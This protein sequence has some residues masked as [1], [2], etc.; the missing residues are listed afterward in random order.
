MML[1]GVISAPNIKRGTTMDGAVTSFEEE[2]IEYLS[3]I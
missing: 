1:N 2:R 3:L